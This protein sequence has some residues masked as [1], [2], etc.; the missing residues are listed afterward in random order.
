MPAID[1]VNASEVGAFVSPDTGLS[2][3]PTLGPL[4]FD[5]GYWYYYYPG[6][7]CFGRYSED[8]NEQSKQC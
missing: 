6:G 5:F 4:A 2:V 7:Q 1:V 3:R 8:E